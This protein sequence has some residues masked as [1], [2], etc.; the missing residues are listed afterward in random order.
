MTCFKINNSYLYIC[1]II[2]L[3]SRKVIGYRTSLRNSTQLITKTF[4]AAFIER[5]ARA[6]LVFHSDRGANYTS[7]SFQKL[8]KKLGVRQSFSLP[9]KPHDNA[10]AEAFFATLKREYLYR[11]NFKSIKE[12]QEKLT[13]YMEFYNTRRPH[14]TLNHRTPCVTEELFYSSE[15]A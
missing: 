1:S 14:K 6:G 11:Y 9:G 12:V 13:E 10:V 3:Y 7:N 15:H 2:D 8:L 4:R 5:N